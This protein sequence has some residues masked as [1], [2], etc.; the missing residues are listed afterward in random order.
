MTR[1]DFLDE[2]RYDAPS[3]PRQLS[4]LDEELANKL[5]AGFAKHAWVEK[6]E[7]VEIRRPKQIIVKLT[8]R[9]PVLAVKVGPKLRAV[10]GNGILLPRNAPTL[11]LPVYEGDAP[12]PQKEAG[13]P[14]GD[15]NVEATARRA[16]K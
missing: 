12:P 13:T 5:R 2:V 16:K 4:L 14:W 3:L 11:G 6:V 1:Q 7:G 10:D 15:P 8:Y 9:T